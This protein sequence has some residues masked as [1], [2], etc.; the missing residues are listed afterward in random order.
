MGGKAI[1]LVDLENSNNYLLEKGTLQKE[2]DNNLAFLVSGNFLI[3]NCIFSGSAFAL[4]TVTANL[5]K[6][7]D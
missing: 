1:A 2:F 5:I 3:E 6:Y 7:L 4:I